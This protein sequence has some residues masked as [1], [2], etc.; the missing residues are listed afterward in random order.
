MIIKSIIYF[1]FLDEVY[2]DELQIIL[3]LNVKAYV[4]IDY[5]NDK[6]LTDD[7]LDKCLD[8]ASLAKIITSY[9]V[10]K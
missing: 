5:H 7:N 9:V 2:A 6:V 10:G 1:S 8:H 3:Q 4:L